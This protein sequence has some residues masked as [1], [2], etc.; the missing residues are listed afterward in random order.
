MEEN[1]VLTLTVRAT[2]ATT[3]LAIVALPH[4]RVPCLRRA[5]GELI[6]GTSTGDLVTAIVHFQTARLAAAVVSVCP[7]TVIQRSDALYKLPLFARFASLPT[8]A[9]SRLAISVCT[10]RPTAR[11]ALPH[12]S[13][14]P[15]IAILG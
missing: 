3:G 7:T 5:P 13:A 12:I 6:A 4:P 8:I 15:A 9:T 10:R 11:T 2:S 1:A 14:S